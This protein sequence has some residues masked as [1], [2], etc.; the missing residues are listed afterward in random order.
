MSDTA[1]FSKSKT[2]FGKDKNPS[3]ILPEKYTLNSKLKFRCHHGVSCFTQCCGNIRIILTPYDILT[4]RKRLDMTAADFLNQYTVPTYL[5]KTDLPGVQIKLNEDDMRCP[6]LI[7]STEGCSVYTDRPTTCRYYPVGMASFHERAEEEQNEEEFYFI[8]K[9][10]HCKGF[11]EE[12]TWTI[13]EWRENQG[14]DLRDRMNKGWMGIVMRRKS[15]GYQ[16]TLSDQAKRMFFMAS[17]DLEQF[18]RF[19]LESSFLDTYEVDQETL[20]KIKSDD[21]ELMH[22]AVRYLAS[23]LFGT[24]YIKIKPEKIKAKIEEVERDQEEI[25]NSMEERAE[26]EVAE[27]K[28]ERERMRKAR[29]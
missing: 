13:R 26:A 5:E 7:S 17:T 25:G 11:E 14:V 29:G 6:F 9:E 2:M 22:F 19:V 23:S 27:L 15:F 1:D 20:D 24:E 10:P 8:V 4:L 28:A 3:N 16:A 18:R 12:K 21:V